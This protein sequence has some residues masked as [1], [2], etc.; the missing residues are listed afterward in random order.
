MLLPVPTEGTIAHVSSTLPSATNLKIIVSSVGRTTIVCMERVLT[1]LRWLKAN[2]RDYAQV[3]LI[4]SDKLIFSLQ[5]NIDANFVLPADCLCGSG[6]GTVQ[7]IAANTGDPTLILHDDINPHIVQDVG[8]QGKRMQGTAYEH[9]L[10]KR[11]PYEPIS[12]DQPDSDANAF[13]WLFPTGKFGLN[14]LRPKKK[15]TEQVHSE[16]DV[17][18]FML[19]YVDRRYATDS[20]FLAFL[21]GILE[22][23]TLLS[24]LGIRA[25]MAKGKLA[26]DSFM[27]LLQEGDP[28]FQINMTSI[29][30]A[31]RGRDAYW[32]DTR[33]NLQAHIA[34]FGPPTWFVTLSPAETDWPEVLEMY[35]LVH[36]TNPGFVMYT[37]NTIRGAIAA[38]PFFFARIF[39]TRLSAT[40]NKLLL[41]AEGPLGTIVHFFYRIEYQQR[42]TEHVHML[43]WAKDAPNKEATNDEVN[44][45]EL[46]GRSTYFTYFNY[47]SKL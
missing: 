13:P 9:Y 20:A 41:K 2:H 29:A 18:R 47:E 45:I 10:L 40:L 38:D 26:T 22:S 15:D 12:V 46:D 11:N 21:H 36:K 24:S 14:H 3:I 23:K 17:A 1:A 19:K 44:N 33:F 37:K 4:S 6:S 7:L 35:N 8:G 32:V 25:R 27:R 28:E 42:G 30:S 16:R 43:L 34:C 5:I 39:Q 31:L